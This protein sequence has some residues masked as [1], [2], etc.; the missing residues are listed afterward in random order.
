[1][2]VVLAALDTTD[3]ARSV[4]E[5]A[6][7]IGRLIGTDVA[8]LHVRSNPLVSLETSELLAAR[9]GVPLRVLEGSVNPTLLDA[10]R[11]P[12]VAAAV[13]GA[14]GASSGRRPVGRTALHIIE[15]LDKPVVLVPPDAVAPTAIRRLLV[16]L[17]G[18]DASSRK[19][20]EHLRPLVVAGVE[21]VVLHV[22]TEATLPT[23]LD[24]P[25]RDLEIL[26]KE[27]LIRHCPV[28]TDIKFRQGPVAATVA[29][30]TEEYRGDLIVLSWSQDNSPGRAMVVRE[31][32]GASTLP[33]LLLPE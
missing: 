28:A 9:V 3:A 4:L 23:M 20:L 30:M 17:E 5:T 15:H 8:A 27:F 7:Q 33:V 6:I 22:F 13:I 32:I 1:M 10:L 2:R 31:V 26:G 19:V 24:R 18:V 21:L 11:A 29:E 12:D 25:Y 16:P 14:R